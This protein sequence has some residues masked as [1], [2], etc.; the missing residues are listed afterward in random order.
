MREMISLGEEEEIYH[1]GFP[2]VKAKTY[3]FA[4]AIRNVEA[5]TILA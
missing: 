4:T 5:S 2:G 3:P 1:A